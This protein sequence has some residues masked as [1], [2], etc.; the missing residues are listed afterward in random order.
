MWLWGPDLGSNSV[1]VVSWL[2]DQSELF[3]LSVSQIHQIDM[4][5]TH[6]INLIR[7]L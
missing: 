7:L 2:C 4:G 6:N 3:H 5:E 1:S